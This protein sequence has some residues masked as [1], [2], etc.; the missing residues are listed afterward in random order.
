MPIVGLACG[1]TFPY[2]QIQYICISAKAAFLAK[3]QSL[4]KI[5]LW[6]WFGCDL[7]GV[8][9]C[10]EIGANLL[11]R[12]IPGV[13]ITLGTYHFFRLSFLIRF[14]FFK[15]FFFYLWLLFNLDLKN[16]WAY[17]SF[18]SSCFL[19]F[20]NFIVVVSYFL[21]KL[22]KT[23]WLNVKF[24]T[25]ITKL[26]LHLHITYRYRHPKPLLTT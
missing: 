9:K 7:E 13:F 10:K 3:Y 4:G 1:S 6:D 19:K 26:Y 8:Y 23:K 2:F 25:Y 16:T 21:G 15:S 18:D 22:R 5:N 24:C 11:L 20:K 12:R 14:R 17:E